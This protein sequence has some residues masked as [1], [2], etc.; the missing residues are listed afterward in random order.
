[1]VTRDSLQRLGVDV[2]LNS[3]VEAVDEIGAVVNGVRVPAAT[4]LW[5]A[6]VVASPAAQWLNEAADTS[7]RL[8][9]SPDLSV[10]RWPNIFAIGDTAASFG[11]N[12]LAVPGLAPAA[13]QAG[14]Y[15]ASVLRARWSGHEPPAPFSYRHRGNLATIGRQSAVADF[16]WITLVPAP[17]GYGAPSIFSSLL[18]SAIE[19]RYFWGGFG[20]ILPTK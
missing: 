8:K 15:V 6:G 17:G 9:V 11:W 10:P 2:R 5:A 18:D 14:A 3:R 12:G 16:G 1:M 13:K 20:P 19:F 4:V 7:G